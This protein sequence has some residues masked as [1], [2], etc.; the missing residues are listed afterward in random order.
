MSGG[1]ETGVPIYLPLSY[2]R[3]PWLF[4]IDSGCERSIVPREMIKPAQVMES[5]EVLRTANGACMSTFGA[6]RIP[7]HAADLIVTVDA[8]VTEDIK[9]PILGADWMKQHEGVL[10]MK[11]GTLQVMGRKLQLQPRE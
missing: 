3:E 9:S 5:D 10:D 6:A 11:E 2:G 4:L 1:R 7:L 8:L